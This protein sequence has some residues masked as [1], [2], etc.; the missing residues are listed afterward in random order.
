[1]KFG[2]DR[3][4]DQEEFTLLFNEALAFL[5]VK[6]PEETAKNIFVR[7]DKD[8]DGKITYAEYFS[9]IA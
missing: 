9:I 7:T 4:M 5:G 1:M 3:K 2:S 6:C 8:K